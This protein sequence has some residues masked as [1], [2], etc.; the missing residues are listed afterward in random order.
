[1]N[2]AAERLPELPA[3]NISNGMQRQTIVQLMVI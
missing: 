2:L 1:M 3:T